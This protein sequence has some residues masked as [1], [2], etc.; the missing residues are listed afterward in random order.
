MRS[1]A[2]AA[3]VVALLVMGAG[4]S[5]EPGPQAP[6][7]RQSVSLISATAL[8]RLVKLHVRVRGGRRWLAYVDGKP[9]ETPSS[10]TVGYARVTTPG[11]HRIF[12]ALA[13][14]P[15][16]RSRTVNVRLAR[17]AGPV[18]AAAG[19][20]ACDPNTNAFNDGRGSV[21]ACHQRATSDLVVNAGLNAVL[22]LGDLQYY[23]GALAAFMY[24]YDPTWGR[25]KSIT[26]PAPGNHEYQGGG[27]YGCEHGAQGYYTYWGWTA[28]DPIGGYYSF[29]LGAWHLISLNS[30]CED[31]GGC[32]PGSAE[33]RWLRADLAAHPARCTL[34]YWHKPRFSSGMHGNDATYTAFWRALY[35]AGADVVLVGHDH[36]YE[37]FAAQ[38]PAGRADP[39]R[40]IRQFVVGTGG[41]THYGFRTI[42]ANS[43]VRNSGTFGVLRLTLHP[44]GY[45][46]RFVPEPGK[47]FTDTGHGTCH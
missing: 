30:N 8:Q 17:P 23:C 42:R 39:S 3:G 36:D 13:G 14:Q 19:D 20:I 5:A 15:R 44:S 31:I 41:K 37:R 45:D 4:A 10:E 27:A 11:A 34:A 12:V 32:G 9:S 16:I 24:S 46:W 22:A 21:R 6:W 28:G 40:G 18:I 38:T 7:G 1:L 25:V 2:A 29:D 26:Y 35:R 47:T 43:R 33:E